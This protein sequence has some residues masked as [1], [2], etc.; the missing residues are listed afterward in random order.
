LLLAATALL[1][2][3]VGMPLS[4]R[5]SAWLE[6]PGGMSGRASRRAACFSEDLQRSSNAIRQRLPD[7]TR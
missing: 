4:M 1:A 5:V 7:R 3:D 6:R 2:I